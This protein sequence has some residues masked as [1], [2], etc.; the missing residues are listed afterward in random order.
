MSMPPQLRRAKRP[1]RTTPRPIVETLPRIDITDL[2]R[3][4]VFPSQYDWHKAHLLELP[5]RYPFLKNLVISLQA[6]EA[7]IIQ[8][9]ISVFHC[10]GYAQVSEG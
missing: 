8:A 1:K 2:C 7:I 10:V 3:W 6:I 4:N 5:F 9:I